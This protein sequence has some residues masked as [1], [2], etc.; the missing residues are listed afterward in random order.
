[1]SQVTGS[2]FLSPTGLAFWCLSGVQYTSTKMFKK[3]EENN[4]G[5]HAF[6]LKATEDIGSAAWSGRADVSIFL[7]RSSPS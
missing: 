5:P 3:P 6:T 2:F 4:L 7:L 1:M